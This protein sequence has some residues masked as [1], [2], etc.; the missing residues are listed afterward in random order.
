MSA[1]NSVFGQTVWRFRNAAALRVREIPVGSPFVAEVVRLSRQVMTCLDRADPFHGAFGR[2]VWVLRTRILFTL[3]PFD[4]VGLSLCEI[5]NEIADDAA[6]IPA[7][8]KPV[9]DLVQATHALLEHPANPKLIRTRALLEAEAYEPRGSRT[10][11]VAA[12]ALGRTFGWPEKPDGMPDLPADPAIIDSRKTLASEAFGRIIVLGTC[13][14]L[15]PQMFDDLFYQG[16]AGEI[17]VLL[18]PGEYFALRNRQ[19]LPESSVF[20]G[21]LSTTRVISSRESISD[22]MGGEEDEQGGNEESVWDIAHDGHRAPLPRHRAARYVLFRDA[23]GIFV[24]EEAHLLV[25]KNDSS[26]EEDSELDS[27]PVARL[28]E[29][30]WLVLRPSGTRYLLDLESAEEGFGQKLEEACNWQPAL[31]RLLLTRS[32]D[33]IAEEMRAAGAN[34]RSLSQSL[35]NWADGSVYGPGHRGELGA[36]FLVLMKHGKLATPADMNDYVN[37]HWNGLQE[38]RSLRQRAAHSVRREICSQLSN[39]LGHLRVLPEDGHVVLENGV[40]VQLCQVAAVDDHMAWV[41]PSR[42]MDLQPMKGI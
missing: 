28:A 32:P 42:L 34:G 33:V 5:L 25:W 21:R 40:R 27:V 11:I 7:L 6:S 9:R 20:R 15:S 37:A 36:L 35:R 41:P 17:N 1:E 26:T 12:M 8:A 30:D 14:Y 4:H 24:P 18:Y 22:L 13:R 29:G 16:R 3:L 38:L 10:G 39:V 19:T 2:R 31:E 23:R